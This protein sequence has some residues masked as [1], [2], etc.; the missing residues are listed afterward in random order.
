[1]LAGARDFL[2]KPPTVDELTSAIHRAGEMAKSERAKI[3]SA[4]TSTTGRSG[5]QTGGL[6]NSN[7]GSV[8]MVYSPKGGTGCSTIATNLAISLQN[9]DTPVVIVDGNLQFGDIAV[10]LN[11]QIRYSIIDLVTRTDELDNDLLE[12]V[13]IHHAASGIRVLAAPTRPEYAENVSGDHISKILSFLRRRFS[14]II[15]DTSSILTDIVLATMDETDIYVLV[16]NQD[17]PSIKSARVYMDLLDGLKIERQRVI[18]VMNKFD[19][20]IAITPDRVGDSFKQEI[21][22]VI[23]LE[24]RVVL[25]SVN[26]GVPFILKDK[27]RPVARSV[28][29]HAEVVRQKVAAIQVGVEEIA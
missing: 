5:V 17:I 18:L 23:P 21:S 13:L 16:I 27:S 19:K 9:K 10:F 7:L 22:A 3:V 12:E 28:L 20:R 2:S 6:G 15:V 29:A 8:I 25:P 14:Y 24:E 11:E 1:M 4:G 26:R